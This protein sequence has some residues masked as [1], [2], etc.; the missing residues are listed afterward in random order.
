[1][2]ISKHSHALPCRV[3][4]D[5][6]DHRIVVTVAAATISITRLEALGLVTINIGIRA[7]RLCLRLRCSIAHEQHGLG[8]KAVRDA[9]RR[10]RDRQLIAQRVHA[11][12]E[13]RVLLAVKGVLGR[14]VG[15]ARVHVWAAKKGT[16]MQYQTQSQ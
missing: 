8:R 16:E 14:R 13:P 1:M 12:G 5:G 3:Q 4:K 7:L 10:Q 9:A 11:T 6:L 15:V 2:H